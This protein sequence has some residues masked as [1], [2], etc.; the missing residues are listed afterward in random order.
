MTDARKLLGPTVPGVTL[1]LTRTDVAK[2][3][4]DTTS[5]RAAAEGGCSAAA[6]SEAAGASSDNTPVAP[7]IPAAM[8]TSAITVRLSDP[9]RLV[10]FVRPGTFTY[11]FRAPKATRPA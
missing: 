10:P 5:G 7:R 8:A 4:P 9:T 6:A 3:W 11:R 2:S 1:N